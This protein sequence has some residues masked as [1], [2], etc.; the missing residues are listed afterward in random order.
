MDK[1]MI[2]A[3]Q[4][5]AVEILNEKDIDMWLTFVRETGN[6]PDPMMDMIV[7]TGA[8]WH[9]AFIITRNGILQL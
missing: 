2:L 7:G 3:K 1:E 9:S 4:K 5:Q 8:T 6:I